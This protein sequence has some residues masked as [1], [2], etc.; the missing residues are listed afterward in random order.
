MAKGYSDS[1]IEDKWSALWDALKETADSVLGYEG[2]KQPDWYSESI[3]T[4]EPALKQRNE[5]YQRWLATGR[6]KD[7]TKFAKAWAS[8]RRTVREAKNAW[9]RSK[10]EE[11]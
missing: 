6:I 7:H 3:D 9:F 10:A 1:T 11:A 2:K 4:I 8:A 5:C